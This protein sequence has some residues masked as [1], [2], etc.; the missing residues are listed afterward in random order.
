MDEAE[1]AALLMR[2]PPPAATL[3]WLVDELDVAEVVEVSP[4]PGGS[5][6]AMHRVALI[7]RGGH[8]QSVVLRRYVRETILATS[9]DVAAVEAR[10]LQLAERLPLPTPTLLALDATGD[11]ADV[12][13]LVM[14]LLDGR[15][16]WETRWGSGWVSQTVDAMI[17]LHDLDASKSTCRHSPRTR[18]SATTHRDALGSR[19]THRGR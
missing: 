6:S 5:T 18:R 17:A 19:S 2:Q 15:P 16:I 7:D 4:M 14:S 13:A 9:P 12:P 1:H 10:A 8:Q 11:R 3:A